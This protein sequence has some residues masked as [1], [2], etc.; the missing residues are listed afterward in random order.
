MVAQI[1]DAVIFVQNFGGAN[2]CALP[3]SHLVT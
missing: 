3:S 2:V 1:N